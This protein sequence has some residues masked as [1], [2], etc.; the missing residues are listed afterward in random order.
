M[1]PPAFPSA[2]QGDPSRLRQVLTNLVGN[3]IKFTERGEVAIVV[4]VVDDAEHEVG[5][6]LAVRDTG[7]GIAPDRLD[8]IFESFT[9]ADGSSTRRHGGTGLG[10]TISRQLVALMGGAIAVESAIGQGSTFVVRSRCRSSRDRGARVPPA[11]LAGV[12]CSS[13][14]TTP[15]TA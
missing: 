5:L 1:I 6:E 15:R 7:I 13:S 14:T 4:R 10:L 9:Q 12:A 2:V 11:A 8:A 3:A